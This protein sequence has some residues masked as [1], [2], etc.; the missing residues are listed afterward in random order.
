MFSSNEYVEMS[1]MVSKEDS[2]LIVAPSNHGRTT[3][4]AVLLATVVTNQGGRQVMV[5]KPNSLSAMFNNIEAKY[6]QSKGAVGYALEE[7]Q[8]YKNPILTSENSDIFTPLVYVTPSFINKKILSLLREDKNDIL[9]C[10][11]LIIDEAFLGDIETDLTLYLWNECYNTGKKVPKLVMMSSFFNKTSM[12]SMKYPTIKYNNDLAP[13]EYYDKTFPISSY[14]KFDNFFSII[15]SYNQSNPLNDNSTDV[16]VIFVPTTSEVLKCFNT[17]KDEDLELIRMF[18]L[19]VFNPEVD[20][21]NHPPL[22][23]KR[24]VI[25]TTRIGETCG[26]KASMVFDSLATSQEIKGRERIVKVSKNEANLRASIASDLIFRHCTQSEYNSIFMDSRIKEAKN[27]DLTSTTLHLI[28]N[29]LNPFSFYEKAGLHK[30]AI[31]GISEQ[32]K[33]YELIEYNELKKKYIVT[34]TG[35]FINQLGIPMKQSLVLYKWIHNRAHTK[36]NSLYSAVSL[37]ALLENNIVKKINDNVR[38]L[39][40][41]GYDYDDLSLNLAVYLYIVKAA[42]TT[43]FESKKNIIYKVC[44]ALDVS[45]HQVMEIGSTINKWISKLIDTYSYIKDDF[46]EVVEIS[47]FKVIKD[48]D[49]HIVDVYKWTSKLNMVPEKDMIYSSANEHKVYKWKPLNDS[50]I[51]MKNRPNSIYILSSGL[52]KNK[53]QNVVGVTQQ[54]FVSSMK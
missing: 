38:K 13:I 44:K 32:V 6:N 42:E 53:S 9:W 3:N 33:S 18:T 23:G 43:H 21:L 10:D 39:I 8:D 35:K 24:R 51:E 46:G 30:N 31:D 15:K 16:W 12:I 5:V 4:L 37:I 34:D 20:K 49:R 48:F 50:K 22:D 28:S 19:D 52:M 47:A 41:K 26:L 7:S 1:K 11:I 45:F 40:V 29:G 27:V 25:I 36:T 17:L 2:S 54:C 14:E